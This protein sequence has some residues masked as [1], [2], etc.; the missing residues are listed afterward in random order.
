MTV[1]IENLLASLAEELRLAQHE[2]ATG[3]SDS[4]LQSVVSLLQRADNLTKLGQSVAAQELFDSAAH[5][6]SDS[7]SFRAK[8]ATELFEFVKAVE[9]KASKRSHREFVPKAN[10]EDPRGHPG[11]L[12]SSA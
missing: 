3:A 11:G 1:Q 10:L 9:H 5:Q 12:D 7:W 6:V 8:L 2:R 4:S